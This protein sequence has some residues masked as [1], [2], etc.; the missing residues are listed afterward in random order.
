MTSRSTLWALD[1]QVGILGLVDGQPLSASHSGLQVC[2]AALCVGK[3]VHGVVH[4]LPAGTNVGAFQREVCV[5]ALAQVHC[6]LSRRHVSSEV[7]RCV[8]T[9]HM[10]REGE[11]AILHPPSGRAGLQ[12]TTDLFSLGSVHVHVQS[13]DLQVAIT[14]HYRLREAFTTKVTVTNL[15]GDLTYVGVGAAILAAAGYPAGSAHVVSEMLAS[16]NGGAASL[17]GW[18]SADCVMLF[19]RAPQPDLSLLLLPS[20]FVLGERTIRVHVAVANPVRSCP[21]TQPDAPPHASPVVQ[22]LP[23]RRPETREEARDMHPLPS[24]RSGPHPPTK[25]SPSP[26]LPKAPRDVLMPQRLPQGSPI[27]PNDV[28]DRQPPSHARERSGGQGTSVADAV[29]SWRKASP[30]PAATPS[31]AGD[32]VMREAR[33]VV[34]S[35]VGKGSGSIQCRAGLGSG[36]STSGDSVSSYGGASPSGKGSSH[37]LQALF[38]SGSRALSSTF[39]A[40]EVDWLRVM[41]ERPLSSSSRGGFFGKRLEDDLA[42][43]LH[44]ILQESGPPIFSSSLP[45]RDDLLRLFHRSFPSVWKQFAS[46]THEAQLAPIVRDNLLAAAQMVS[47]RYHAFYVSSGSSPLRHSRR[48]T[49]HSASLVAF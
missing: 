46:T 38:S 16:S 6:A 48:C 20:S 4:L 36:G 11:L 33:G 27:L 43:C 10:G 24:G 41:F 2:A 3:A 15:P 42:G 40:L 44:S 39:T 30:L 45:N 35:P 31:S 47:D 8:E 25:P 5:A 14:G 19:I 23:V 22:D 37:C 49:T 34:A 29:T 13:L 12:V 26:P 1:P 28:Q 9:L 17:V 32:V 21:A 7:V 18:T